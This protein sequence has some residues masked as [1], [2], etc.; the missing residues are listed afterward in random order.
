MA[1][2]SFELKKKVVNSYLNGEGVLNLLLKKRKTRRPKS[3]RKKSNFW[4]HLIM[5]FPVRTF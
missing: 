2:Y 1:K 5:H 4:G 3:S